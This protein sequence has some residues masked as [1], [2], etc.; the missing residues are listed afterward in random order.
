MMTLLMA[1]AMAAQA[2]AANAHNSMAN[3]SPKE[4]QAGKD[5]CM[6]GCDDM[7]GMHEKRGSA[8]DGNAAK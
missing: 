5:C 6:D 8:H 2:P 7:A 4:Q 1:A 3:M